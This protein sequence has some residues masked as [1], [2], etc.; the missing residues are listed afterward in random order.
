MDELKEEMGEIDQRLNECNQ[1]TVAYNW[2]TALPFKGR[3]CESNKQQFGDALRLQHGWNM[4]NIPETCVCGKKIDVNH[5]TSCKKGGFITLRHKK[6]CNLTTSGLDVSAR[7]FW[8]TV[9]KSIL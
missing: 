7:A 5:A 2:L 6:C 9:Q 4:R 3:R 8:S 1:M